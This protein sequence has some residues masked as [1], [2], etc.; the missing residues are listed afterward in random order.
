MNNLKTCPFCG[1]KAKL[2]GGRVYIIPEYEENGIYVEAD[3][4]V[5]PSFVECQNCHS[6]GQSFDESDEAPEKAIEAW[7]RRTNG[8]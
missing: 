1:G 2:M 7:N 8:K 3:I 5:E 6:M 4:E